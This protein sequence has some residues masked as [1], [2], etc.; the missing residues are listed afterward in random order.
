MRNR[1][2]PVDAALLDMRDERSHEGF[3][4][5]FAWL[6]LPFSMRLWTR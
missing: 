5:Y 4:N 6:D 1:A 3:G 2:F